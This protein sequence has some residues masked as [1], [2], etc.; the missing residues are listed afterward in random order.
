MKRTQKRIRFYRSTSVR[1]WRTG[2]ATLGL[3]ACLVGALMMAGGCPQ[4]PGP[5]CTSDLDCLAGQVCEGGEC[6]P[7][8]PPGPYCAPELC[9]D[10]DPCTIEEC[11]DTDGDG[12]DECLNTPIECPEGLFCN[13]DTGEC[14]V[15]LPIVGRHGRGTVTPAG[16]VVLVSNP[17]DLAYGARVEIPGGALSAEC[18][19][20]VDAVQ[21]FPDFP[22]DV[23]RIGPGGITEFR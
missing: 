5:G 18:E 8:E 2:W 20:T 11:V 15:E 1:R 9:D 10:D 23:Q 7:G 22:E 16:G 3:A 14:D 19:I 4:P 21:E 12:G 17:D 6:V 13:P